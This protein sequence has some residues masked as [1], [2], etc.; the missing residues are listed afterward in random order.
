MGRLVK[1]KPGVC[2]CLYLCPSL[3]VTCVLCRK[4]S[5]PQFQSTL[6]KTGLV[7]VRVGVVLV[8]N[9]IRM[10]RVLPSPST[11]LDTSSD[12]IHVASTSVIERWIILAIVLDPTSHP[13]MTMKSCQI[14]TPVISVVASVE[15]DMIVSCVLTMWT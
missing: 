10:I 1:Q 5:C 13:S 14:V 6:L 15:W 11:T 3:S 4:L 2:V 12:W 7:A 8:V 9:V